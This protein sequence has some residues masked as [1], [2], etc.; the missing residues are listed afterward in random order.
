MLTHL[1]RDRLVF[2]I[3]QCF[4]GGRCFSEMIESATL[5]RCLFIKCHFHLLFNSTSCIV[6]QFIFA[7]CLWGAVCV[8]R[9]GVRWYVGL[10]QRGE[11]GN[12]HPEEEKKGEKGGKSKLGGK[13]YGGAVIN[14]AAVL[15]RRIGLFNI[16]CNPWPDS[17]AWKHLVAL[18]SPA[19]GR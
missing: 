1:K 13:S 2:L 8:M 4:D 12:Q 10:I 7:N 3:K 15:R 17:R 9:R 11:R 14:A 5:E 18:W 6:M 19:S 16:A